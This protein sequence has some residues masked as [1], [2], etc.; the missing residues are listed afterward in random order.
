MTN[1]E[2]VKGLDLS[3][4]A[5]TSEYYN[6]HRTKKSG[7]GWYLNTTNSDRVAV[8]AISGN[9]ETY[10]DHNETTKTI[11]Q[12]FEWDKRTAQANNGGYMLMAVKMSHLT[13]EVLTELQASG[14][15]KLTFSFVYHTTYQ[16]AL[17][18]YTINFDY[19]K[20]NPTMSCYYPDNTSPLGVRK[21]AYTKTTYSGQYQPCN[22]QTIEYSLS[23]LITYYD[24]IFVGEYLVLGT[25]ITNYMNS[26]ATA[27]DYFYMSNIAIS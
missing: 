11:A 24:Q 8:E 15:E 1:I 23:D 27:T 26:D 10:T 19:L 25:A 12:K 18:V 5:P 7:T 16:W 6:F 4:L 21:A 22:W 14:K 2:L 3:N 9:G 17:D 13:K 20:A